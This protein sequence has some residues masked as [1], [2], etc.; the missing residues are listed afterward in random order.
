MWKP[1]SPW[2][3]AKADEFGMT[4]EKDAEIMLKHD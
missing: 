2:R 1:V 4:S 3:R